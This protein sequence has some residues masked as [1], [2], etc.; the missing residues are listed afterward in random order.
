MP[1][2]NAVETPPVSALSQVKNGYAMPIWM[3]W[4]NNIFRILRIAP[5]ISSGTAAPASTPGKVGD[6]Y[7]DTSA[8]K[9]Y[10]AVGASS[11]AD[12]EI[13]N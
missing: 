11:S 8:R 12:W 5:S 13:A 6:I 4:F 7:V 9:L 2:P 1:N 10:F 3:N